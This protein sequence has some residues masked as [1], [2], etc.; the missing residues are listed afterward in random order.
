MFCR[1]IFFSAGL[2]LA[3]AAPARACNLALILAVDV[4]GSVSPGEYKIQMSGLAEALRDGAVSEALVVAKAA[5]SLI[6]WTGK[7]R[8]RVTI[9]WVRVTNFDDTDALADQIEVQP[10]L[11]QHFSTAIGEALV[12]AE[13][14]FGDVADC[15]R[16]VID[17]S[18]D[19]Y[20]NEGILP[21]DVWPLLEA[22]GI[23]VNGL[24]IEADEADLSAYFRKDVIFGPGAFAVAADDFQDYPARIRQKLLREITKQL[25]SLR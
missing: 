23:T 19:G 12:L 6:Q 8:Q 7:S 3:M 18:G 17:V 16:R 11:W 20:S 4:S 13:A 15:K 10:R 1:A 22:S 9:P 25:A 5:V 2:A 14:S 24:A 21:R